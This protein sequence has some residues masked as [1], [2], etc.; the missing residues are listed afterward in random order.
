[1]GF[2]AG[3]DTTDEWRKWARERGE[4]SDEPGLILS[5]RL[6][7]S[8]KDNTN[9][10]P[11]SP[12]LDK[13]TWKEH[14]EAAVEEA[15]EMKKWKKLKFA[16]R[17][18]YPSDDSTRPSELEYQYDLPSGTI[19]YGK[20]KNNPAPTNAAAAAATSENEEEEEEEEVEE[21]VEAEED[22]EEEEEEVEEEAKEEPVAEKN[23]SK[24]AESTPPPP[25]PPAG[26]EPKPEV[27]VPVAATIVQ[28]PTSAPPMIQKSPSPPPPKPSEPAYPS[29]MRSSSPPQG[30]FG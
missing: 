22:E 28:P 13:T 25:P 19:L 30:K 16:V 27:P 10:F 24:P 5:K 2:R 8:G 23:I 14:E 17:L 26:S 7:G 12:L 11:K 4:S 21:E 20:V 1:M 3:N 6:G 18:D 29:V 9:L 15:S